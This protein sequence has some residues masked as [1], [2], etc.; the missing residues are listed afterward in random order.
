MEPDELAVV[1]YR[2]ADAEV[3]ERWRFVGRKPAPRWLWQAIDDQRDEVLADVFGRGQDA[4]VVKFKALLEP[5][6]LNRYDTDH[7]GAYPR[8]LDAAEHWSGKRY[9]QTIER[10]HLGLRTRSKR[11]TRRPMCF[12][13]SIERLDIVTGLFINRPYPKYRFRIGNH[14][15]NKAWI[16]FRIKLNRYEFGVPV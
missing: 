12:S 3:D 8:H 6:G 15:K 13:K 4:V 7:D 14:W 11:L 1:L 5:F 10:Q 2:V 16:L 9:P